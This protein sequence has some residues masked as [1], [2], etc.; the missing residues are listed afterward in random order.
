MEWTPYTGSCTNTTMAMTLI[1]PFGAC[2]NNT[3]F[4]TAQTGRQTDGRMDGWTDR[5][6]GRQTGR[7]ADIMIERETQRETSQI[8]S[9]CFG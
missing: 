7:Q 9:F 6:T 8:T 1:Q 5:Q 4:V 2:N 3:R